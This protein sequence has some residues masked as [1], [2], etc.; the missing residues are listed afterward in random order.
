MTKTATSVQFF[1]FSGPELEVRGI[2]HHP[3]TRDCCSLYLVIMMTMM[4]MMAVV[5]V[6]G[7]MVF[8]APRKWV[9]LL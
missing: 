4:T 8:I 7:V 9:A 2:P 6:M 1:A 5:L 3:A